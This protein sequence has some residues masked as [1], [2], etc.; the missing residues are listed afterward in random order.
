MDARIANL[1]DRS[2]TVPAP[3]AGAF[4]SMPSAPGQWVQYKMTL[5]DGEPKFLTKK[6]I[7]EEGG[8][9]WYEIVHET[10]EGRTIEQLLV[11]GGDRTDPEQVELRAVRKKDEKGQVTT[12]SRADLWDAKHQMGPADIYM[13]HAVAASLIIHWRGLPQESTIVPAGQFEGCYRRHTEITRGKK[14]VEDSWSHPEVPLGGLVR[15][16]IDPRYVVE[17]V[18]YGM[19]GARSDF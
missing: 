19:T 1:R 6:V 9:L 11:A 2:T 14:R 12:L 3:P 17:L 18:A 4:A 10:Y 5:F 7:G 15:M 8:A 16:Q 13:E